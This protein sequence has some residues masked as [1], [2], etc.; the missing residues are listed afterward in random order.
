MTRLSKETVIVSPHL[1]HYCRT[2]QLRI[3]CTARYDT[4]VSVAKAPSPALH[5][6]SHSFL[7]AAQNQ[8]NYM[9]GHQ[10]VTKPAT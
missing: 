2:H 8:F 10:F 9:T 4:R 3:Q 6:N 5:E 1:P 7:V